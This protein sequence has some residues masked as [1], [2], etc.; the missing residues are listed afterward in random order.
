[1]KNSSYKSVPV[2]ATVIKSVSGKAVYLYNITSLDGEIV[3]KERW[4]PQTWNSKGTRMVLQAETHEQQLVEFPLSLKTNGMLIPKYSGIHGTIVS[5]VVNGKSQSYY[6]CIDRY[7]IHI[8]LWLFL[9]KKKVVNGKQ[10]VEENT[11]FQK[12]FT[13]VQTSSAKQTEL[14]EN[15]DSQYT[16]AEDIAYRSQVNKLFDYRPDADEFASDGS[17]EYANQSLKQWYADNADY[18]TG[19]AS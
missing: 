4:I 5:R 11:G 9:P 7:L 6:Q 16:V 14:F 8:P 18:V 2:L 13:K 19:V 3:Y 15:D 10:V 12:K 17:L 1:M